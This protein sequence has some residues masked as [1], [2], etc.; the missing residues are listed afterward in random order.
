MK[1][2]NEWSQDTSL[3]SIDPAF[4]E[5]AL[6][7]HG[8]DD[9]AATEFLKEADARL[10]SGIE[11]MHHIMM[12]DDDYLEDMLEYYILVA[13]NKLRFILTGKAEAIGAFQSQHA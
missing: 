5:L 4:I 10:G 9:A 11:Y 1:T 2:V 13:K 8:G 6:I 12:C 3:P 7:A